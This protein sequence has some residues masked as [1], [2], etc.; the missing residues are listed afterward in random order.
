[1]K[2]HQSETCFHMRAKIKIRE[3]YWCKQHFRT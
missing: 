1:M 2:Y 3:I